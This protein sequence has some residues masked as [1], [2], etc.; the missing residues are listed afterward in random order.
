MLNAA[1]NLDTIAAELARLNTDRPASLDDLVALSVARDCI[2]ELFRSCTDELRADPRVAP[3]LNAMTAA[4]K[5]QPKHGAAK[6]KK[7]SCDSEQQVLMFW[8]AFAGRFAWD[9]L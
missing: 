2:E 5:L 8:N 6:Q 3:L 4:I 1:Q 7:E 9:F